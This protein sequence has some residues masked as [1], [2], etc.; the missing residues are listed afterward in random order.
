MDMKFGLYFFMA[1]DNMNQH[2]LRTLLTLLGLVVGISS[3]LVMTGI[4]RG[5]A[6]GAEEQLA[7]L[8]PNKISLRQGY[9]PDAPPVSLTMREVALLEQHIGRTAISAVA[10]KKQLWDL[11]IKGVDPEF[12]GVMVTATTADYLQ[13]VNLNFTQ[14]RFFTADEAR[15]GQFV[16]VASQSALDMVQQ[17]GQLD[18]S[19]LQ[20][21]N[22]PFRV[23]GVT[24]PDDGPFSFGMPELFIPI[25]LLQRDLNTQSLAV[26]NGSLVVEEIV[27]MAQ[28]VAHLEEAKRDIERTMR[29]RYGLTATQGNNFEIWVEGDILGF[30]QD[31]N[32]GFTLVL[33][34]IG[35]VALVVGGIGIMNILLASITERTRE[36]GLRKAI[37]ANNRD[38]LIQFLIEAI[39]ICL[40]GGLLGVA[41]S[42]GV[43]AII[44]YFTGGE[45]SMIGLRVVIDLRSVI[46]AAVSSTLCGIIFGLYPA[47]RAMRL[48]PIEA[49][50]TS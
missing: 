14:G 46:I 12:G 18:L 10:P 31:F 30:A 27:V 6:L 37:G 29:L 47:L 21:D 33:G 13:T 50:R 22:K 19:T 44:N 42:Y 41:F 48:N 8:L 38:I 28:D 1:L 25:N 35:A 17:S 2:K 32:R 5:F 4:G 36:I 7:T 39:T 40:A 20:I 43:G 15:E 11:P 3:V 26:E 16:V 49:L 24:A 23:V 9:S 45:Q 34:G